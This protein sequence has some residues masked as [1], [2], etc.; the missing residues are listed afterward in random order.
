MTLMVGLFCEPEKIA[1]HS[2]ADSNPRFRQRVSEEGSV[3]SNPADTVFSLS[4]IFGL[5]YSIR[6]TEIG[7]VGSAV[8]AVG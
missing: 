7:N 5:P 4:Q 8:E 6:L 2:F 3:P 1:A